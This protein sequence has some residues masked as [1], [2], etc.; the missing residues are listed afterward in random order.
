[1]AKGAP[2][3]KLTLH[4]QPLR[5]S[6]SVLMVRWNEMMA[7]AEGIRDPD[8]VEGLHNMRIAAKRLR[9]TME[10]FAPV[11]P[12]SATPVLTTIE[13]IQ[14]RI[15]K[16]HDCDVLFPL[17]HDTIQSEMKRERKDVARRRD[18]G[19]PPHLAAEG[20]VALI[21]RKRA[22]RSALYDDFLGWWEAL[23]PASLGESLEQVVAGASGI[24]TVAP[25]ETKK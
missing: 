10:I 3:H 7:W 22:E 8:N 6:A 24:P 18:V 5:V 2:I 13:E 11:L 20:L 12:D 19:P 16:I 23:P 21:A 25:E 4:G 9:Y 17:L 1:M 15:G 14:E